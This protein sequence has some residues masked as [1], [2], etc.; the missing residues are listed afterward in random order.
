MPPP[1]THTLAHAH[2]C[3]RM[4]LHT[5]RCCAWSTS[6]Q[7][8]QA[9]VNNGAAHNTCS[10]SRPP[11]NSSCAGPATVRGGPGAAPSGSNPR[12]TCKSGG[13]HPFHRCIHAACCAAP[14]PTLLYFSFSSATLAAIS[15]RI[16]AATALPSITL[17]FM[18]GDA[19]GAAAA[20]AGAGSAMV[21]CQRR[22]CGRRFGSVNAP[23]QGHWAPTYPYPHWRS[24]GRRRRRS[25]AI[26]DHLNCLPENERQLRA[27]Q[28]S[29]SP[30]LPQALKR[31]PGG[32]GDMHKHA[33]TS[34][35]PQGAL[36]GHHRREA[37][38][39]AVGISSRRRPPARRPPLAP[40]TGR[41]DCVRPHAI[42]C[43]PPST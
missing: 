28:G 25:M 35:I 16:L 24:G 20:A 38:G 1:H 30:C 22:V 10:F 5:P 36:G 14:F 42:F 6:H 40:S 34:L 11:G 8:Q 43:S 32:G 33:S 37:A 27:G 18:N 12:P 29:S 26:Y 39:Q 41:V 17:P 9:T 3:T 23:P 15:S 4:K 7:G 13:G 19:G 2:A 31:K 21:V